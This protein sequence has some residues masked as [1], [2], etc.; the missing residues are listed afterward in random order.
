MWLI[1]SAAVVP[2][3]AIGVSFQALQSINPFL[4]L[5]VAAILVPIYMYLVKLLRPDDIRWI[6][7]IRRHSA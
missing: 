1:V 6:I 3:L 4:R 7:N 5:G 2:C